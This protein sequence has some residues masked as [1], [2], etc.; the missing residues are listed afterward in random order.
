VTSIAL[1]LLAAVGY[2]A[3]TWRYT[4]W[5]RGP[6]EAP[7]VGRRELLV[8]F[9]IH[10]AG[11]FAWGMELGRCPNRLAPETLAF[12]AWLMAALYLG[13]ASRLK[14][15]ILGVF[16]APL[17]ACLMVATLATAL[18]RSAPLAV[19]A[20]AG[21]VADGRH[22]FDVL[23]M[24]HIVSIL[25]GYAAFL[26]ASVLAALYLIRAVQLKKKSSGGWLERLPSLELLDRSTYL[27]IA[28]GFPLLTLGM[29][30]GF[31][32][33]SQKGGTFV[34]TD[35]LL[36]LL[37]LGIYAVYVY[38]RLVAGWQ[39]RRVNQVLLVGFL[40]LL[41]TFVGVEALPLLGKGIHAS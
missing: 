32:R 10:T 13:L 36:G 34:N 24:A 35:V 21:S 19:G 7:M 25:L 2:L 30:L 33:V 14:V 1:L 39:G 11:L 31:V 4:Q 38:T 3:S 22:T 16:A 5:L 28:L 20:V 27:L 18:L 6:S 29:A 15:E 9:G 23:L 8:A 37:T 12:M 40:F 26:L 41:A 17:A